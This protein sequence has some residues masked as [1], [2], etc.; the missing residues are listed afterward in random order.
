MKSVISL[1]ILL[2]IGVVCS[3]TSC[4]N[5]RN[6]DYKTNGPYSIN[7]YV[8]TINGHVILTTVVDS[9]NTND[10]SISCIELEDISYD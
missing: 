2:L 10:V 5:K 3:L 7:Y 4:N 9:K 8:D 6:T 1:G